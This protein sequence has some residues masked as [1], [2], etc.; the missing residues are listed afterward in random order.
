MAVG[1][2]PSGMLSCFILILY[3]SFNQEDLVKRSSP[4]VD[5]IVIITLFIKIQGPPHQ[6]NS[7]VWSL[8]TRDYLENEKT[9]KPSSSGKQ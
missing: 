1:M 8:K 7:P 4:E 9:L 6:G 3:V 2:H 5:S